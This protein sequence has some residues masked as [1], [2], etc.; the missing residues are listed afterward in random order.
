[1]E[2]VCEALNA[3]IA[4]QLNE[5]ILAHYRANRIYKSRNHDKLATNQPISIATHNHNFIQ[6]KTMFNELI[7]LKELKGL[8][9]IANLRKL[10]SRN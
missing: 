3:P 9:P 10:K 5:R 7:R 2:I 8:K 1:M 4:N 6:L